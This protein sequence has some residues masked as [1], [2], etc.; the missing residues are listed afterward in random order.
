[1]PQK[2]VTNNVKIPI[3]TQYGFI[4]NQFINDLNYDGEKLTAYLF[5]T[6][7]SRNTFR[8]TFEQAYYIQCTDE[9][10]HVGSWGTGE[11]NLVEVKNSD[12]LKLFKE[13]STFFF[14]W[15]KNKNQ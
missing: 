15:E 10:H 8:V 13:N 1:M 6:D 3:N 7:E 5:D 4:K 2:S 11:V 9:S 14:F 12:V